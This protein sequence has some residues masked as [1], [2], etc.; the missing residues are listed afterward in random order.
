MS[1]SPS[2]G[3][4]FTF[5]ELSFSSGPLICSHCLS[6]G[7]L[8]A[9]Q[10]ISLWVHLNNALH[11]NLV[12]PD[13]QKLDL[14]ASVRH[15]RLLKPSILLALVEV[16]TQ[17]R[18]LANQ[19]TKKCNLEPKKSL[20]RVILSSNITVNIYSRPYIKTPW[21]ILL[22]AAN[23]GIIGNSH[24]L[25]KGVNPPEDRVLWIKMKMM[26]M[27][28][29]PLRAMKETYVILTLSHSQSSWLPEC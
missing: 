5:H 13:Q 4:V 10:L 23:A 1:I 27:S 16:K 28:H 22:W 11:K 17:Q 15:E 7:H 21:K 3:I 14:H 2:R 9:S 18:Q 24:V 29:Q 20:L 19:L 6:V 26:K 8:S 25:T 12:S